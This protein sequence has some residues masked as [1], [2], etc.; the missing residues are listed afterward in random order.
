MG[1]FAAASMVL[2]VLRILDAPNDPITG[3]VIDNIRF[4]WGKVQ[5]A[6]AHRRGDEQLCSSSSCSRTSG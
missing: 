6:H 3:L 2:T 1:V 5:T 4:P